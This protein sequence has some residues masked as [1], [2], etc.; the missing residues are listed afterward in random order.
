MPDDETQQPP[1]AR[2]LGIRMRPRAWMRWL[3]STTRHA[4]PEPQADPS[5]AERLDVHATLR[6]L[7][8]LLDGSTLPNGVVEL[9]IEDFET[10]TR[11]LFDIHDGH[12]TLV[13]PGKCVPWTC[14]AGSATAWASALGPAHDTAGL[15]LTGDERLARCVLAALPRPD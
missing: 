6:A 4:E 5:C 3:A 11:Q 14:I 12:V 1:D 9:L 8:T 15:Q 13:E 7:P 10:P 2:P